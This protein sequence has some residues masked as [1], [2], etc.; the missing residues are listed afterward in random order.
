MGLGAQVMTK[1]RQKAFQQLRPY[2]PYQHDRLQRY[3]N[4]KN[5]S[6]PELQIIKRRR[7][8]DCG[9]SDRRSVLQVHA[10]DHKTYRREHITRRH[11]LER[12]AEYH[13]NGLLLNSL[14]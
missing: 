5:F 12:Q 8:A 11:W 7:M 10:K 1:L 9:S 4:F 6:T 13:F 3:A 14:A 2:H